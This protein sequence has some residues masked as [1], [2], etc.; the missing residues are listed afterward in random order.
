VKSAGFQR[1]NL[2]IGIVSLLGNRK[3]NQAKPD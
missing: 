1:V 2:P 3:Q